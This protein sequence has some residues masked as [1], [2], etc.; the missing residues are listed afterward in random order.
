MKIK[1]EFATEVTEIE[2]DE[3]WA[4]ILID[5]DRLEYNNNHKETR[6]HSS[7]DGYLYENSDFAVDDAGLTELLG[8]NINEDKLHTVLEALP[9]EHQKL[10]HKRYFEGY[11]LDE[12]G[13]MFGI[14]K[15][16]VS[17]KIGR[18]LKKLKRLLE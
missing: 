15:A 8:R 1:Y 6:R 14:R 4:T 11:S 9:P 7:L 3:E 17:R 12:C 18:I 5:L 10:I 13:A 2:V 16:A